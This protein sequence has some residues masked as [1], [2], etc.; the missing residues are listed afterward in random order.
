MEI[1]RDIERLGALENRPKEFV[2]EITTLDMAIEE[3]TLETVIPVRSLQFGGS[4]IGV[5][6]RQRGKSGEA[7]WMTQ[8]GIGKEI[9]RFAGKRRRLSSVELLCAWRSERQYLH[10]YVRGIHFG[11]PLV[12]QFA[13]LLQEF[14]GRTTE[15]Q[16]LFFESTPW[17]IEES[18]GRE[19]FLQ[20]YRSHK[21]SFY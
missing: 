21:H 3:R 7:C 8:H 12:S 20:G 4:G 13:E 15:F 9:V 11:D 2:I 16:R 14:R 6:S 19:M 18:R 1:Y 17:T 5:C 10:V